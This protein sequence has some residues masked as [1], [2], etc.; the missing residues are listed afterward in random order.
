MLLPVTLFWVN[1]QRSVSYPSADPTDHRVDP[2]QQLCRRNTAVNVGCK[3]I[4]LV[5]DITNSVFVRP[6]LSS[7]LSVS[8]PAFPDVFDIVYNIMEEIMVG[9][10]SYGQAFRMVQRK[11]ERRGGCFSTLVVRKQ[12]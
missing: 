6:R 9:R 11:G 12:A 10:L 3:I 7:V 5:R 2:L 8:I 4:H 1:E